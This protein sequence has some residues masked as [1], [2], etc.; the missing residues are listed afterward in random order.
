MTQCWGFEVQNRERKKNQKAEDDCDIFGPRSAAPL[1]WASSMSPCVRFSL[2]ERQDVAH[3]GV[4]Q[5]PQVGSTRPKV[6]AAL[7][8]ML[9]SHLVPRN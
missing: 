6:L 7:R 5:P 1:T 8:I 3:L 2:P 9:I 4:T